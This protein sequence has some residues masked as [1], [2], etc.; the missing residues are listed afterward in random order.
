MTLGTNGDDNTSFRFFCSAG[1]NT[2]AQA[3]NIGVQSGIIYLTGMQV[4]IGNAASA[5]DKPD[6]GTDRRN[7]QRF[8]QLIPFNYTFYGVTG[9]W[10]WTTI[11]YVV[12]MRA[13]PV[14][15]TAGGSSSNGAAFQVNSL[16]TE[17]AQIALQIAATGAASWNSTLFAVADI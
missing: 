7:C 4:E 2:N 10:M 11:N 16:G 9:A 15:N 17:T 12:P 13:S 8:Y 3:G 6:I 14:V 1:T 5:L